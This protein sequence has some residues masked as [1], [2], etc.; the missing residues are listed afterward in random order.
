MQRDGGER[1]RK[2]T[3]ELASSRVLV[4]GKGSR[5]R[6]LVLEEKKGERER[7]KSG[8][9]RET[10]SSLEDKLHLFLPRILVHERESQKT[11]WN[12]PRS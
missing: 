1:E 5:I 3:R 10:S 4:D 12:S 9:E 2:E 7:E 6:H 8:R 11:S